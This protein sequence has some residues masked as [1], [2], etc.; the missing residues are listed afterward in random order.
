[1]ERTEKETSIVAVINQEEN[2][3]NGFVFG[4]EAVAL[5]FYESLNTAITTQIYLQKLP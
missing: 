3:I 4:K 1:M 2:V 5:D